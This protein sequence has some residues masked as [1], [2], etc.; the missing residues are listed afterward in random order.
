MP[1]SNDK[2]KPIEVQFSN[3]DPHQGG[4]HSTLLDLSIFLDLIPI[5]MF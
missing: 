5:P 3:R 1:L 2:F 4:I